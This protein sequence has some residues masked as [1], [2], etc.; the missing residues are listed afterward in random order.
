MKDRQY[1]PINERYDHLYDVMSSQKFK[2]KEGLGNEVPFFICPFKPKEYEQIDKMKTQLFNKLNETGTSILEINLY[3]L[4]IE[5]L[6]ENG[7]FDFI[8]ENETKIDKVLLEEDLKSI[9][10]I[11]DNV[12]PLLAKNMKQNT[13]DILFLTGIGEVY[14][15]IRSHN[16]LN[17]L[18]K[19]AREK[20]TVMFYP[21][22]YK[23][24][25]EKGASLELFELLRDDKYYRAFNIYHYEI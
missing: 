4:A 20:P 19:V 10:D 12:M 25:L 21:G 7:D 11:Q 5:I 18:Q 16:I 14:P 2:N 13:F 23:H 3:D 9:L 1:A 22:D 15:L 17:N 24:S 6:K 8:L